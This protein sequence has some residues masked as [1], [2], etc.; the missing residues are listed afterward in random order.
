M[1]QTVLT[2]I[3]PK[4]TKSRAVESPARPTNL[5]SALRTRLKTLCSYVRN[6]MSHPFLTQFIV[7]KRVR[8]FPSTPRSRQRD[9]IE[10]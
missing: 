1:T 4:Q 7:Q 8:I 9:A 3:E 10:G 2:D 5:L 6:S